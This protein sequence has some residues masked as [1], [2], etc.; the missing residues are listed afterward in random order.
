MIVECIVFLSSIFFL[1][2][3]VL[4]WEEVLCTQR[5]G[6][7]EGVRRGA[8]VSRTLN[9]QN[10]LVSSLENWTPLGWH[11]RESERLALV[12]VPSERDVEVGNGQTW[13]I[14]LHID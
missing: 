4:L 5:F 10:H 14:G 12:L 13:R 11:F 3:V 8:L 6:G 2:K 1:V 7:W 9:Y